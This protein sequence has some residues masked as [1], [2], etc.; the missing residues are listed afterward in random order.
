MSTPPNSH[1][2]FMQWWMSDSSMSRFAGR[3]GAREQVAVAGGVDGDVWR[4]SRD[5]R[6]CSRTPRRARRRPPRWAAPP[7]VVREPHLALEHH[8]LRQE[9]Q[10]LGVDG[11][12]PGHDAVEGTGALRPVRGARGVARAP[13]LARRSR[14]P[15]PSAGARTDLLGEAADHAAAFP[16]GHAVDPDHQPAGGQAAEVVVALE[17]RSRPRPGAPPPPRPPCRKVRRPPPARRSGDRSG[18]PGR[19]RTTRRNRAAARGRHD[20]RCRTTGCARQCE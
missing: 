5:G 16:V 18:C 2:V 20:R 9:L 3:A 10:A 19:V 12:R 7:S 17:Q 13:V 4:G 11:R 14:P 15:R 6:P 8:L 1:A